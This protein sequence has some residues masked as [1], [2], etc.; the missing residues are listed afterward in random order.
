VQ[1]FR[2]SNAQT[3]RKQTRK[4]NS[5]VFR[6]GGANQIEHFSIEAQTM[7]QT[8]ELKSPAEVSRIQTNRGGEKPPRPADPRLVAEILW[9]RRRPSELAKAAR[10]SGSWLWQG[11]LGPGKITLLTAPSKWGKTTLMSNLV[12]RMAAGGELLGLPVA[13]GLPAEP[14]Q[15]TAPPAA[16]PAAP[17]PQPERSEEEWAR[18][19]LRMDPR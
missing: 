13:P 9:K 4:E 6:G 3:K 8:N 15:P 10:H 1:I 5:S 11:Y 16:P 7:S 19:R 12:S 14:K 18:I 17:R 2:Q